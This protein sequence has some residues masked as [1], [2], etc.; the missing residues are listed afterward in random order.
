[1][2]WP[3]CELFFGVDARLSGACIGWS[4]FPP[5]FGNSANS[6]GV[7]LGRVC[8]FVGDGFRCPGVLWVTLQS[9]DKNYT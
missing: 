4:S 2:Q 1:M 7:N 8:C 9:V 5:K 3:E 6:L